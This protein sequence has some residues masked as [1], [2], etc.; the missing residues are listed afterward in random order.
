MALVKRRGV[1]GWQLSTDA[2]GS[3]ILVAESNDSF[4]FEAF[5]IMVSQKLVLLF[6]SS[7][8]M[9]QNLLDSA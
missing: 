2:F 4:P 1:L 3:K 5:R 7:T 6:R 9:V 8:K